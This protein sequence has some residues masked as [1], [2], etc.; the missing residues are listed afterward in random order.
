MV[1][2]FDEFMYILTFCDLIITDDCIQWVE[3]RGVISHISGEDKT[4][5]SFPED[6]KFFS[7]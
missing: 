4:D 3:M 2:I 6:Y 5:Y 1:Y 7:G